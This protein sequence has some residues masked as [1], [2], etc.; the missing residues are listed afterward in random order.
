MSWRVSARLPAIPAMSVTVTP[1]PAPIRLSAEALRRRFNEDVAAFHYTYSSWSIDDGGLNMTFMPRVYLRDD[2][3]QGTAEYRD[4]VRHEERHERDF[5]GLVPRF[6]QQI[7][8]RLRGLD[9]NSAAAV[10]VVRNG[11]EW[12]AYQS[13]LKE[14]TYHRSLGAMVPICRDGSNWG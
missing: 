11:L 13:C 9:P 1:T 5:R 8:R 3:Q 2:L 12:L 4:A 6:R 10:D 7:R 14:R